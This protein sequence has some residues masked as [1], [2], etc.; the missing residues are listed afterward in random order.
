MILQTCIE[1][2]TCNKNFLNVPVIY[3]YW[4]SVFRGCARLSELATIVW[5]RPRDQII[6]GSP[7]DSHVVTLRFVWFVSICVCFSATCTCLNGV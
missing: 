2:T 6:F 1:Y 5:F 4:I 3:D 7:G